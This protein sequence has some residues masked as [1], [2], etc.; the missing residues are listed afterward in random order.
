MG[1]FGPPNVERMKNKRDVAGL[2]K[3]L[4]YRK[5]DKVRQAAMVA[6]G[7]I[8]DARAIE[9]LIAML[10][11]ADDGMRSAAADALG[12]I[13][14]TLAV[15][16]LIA[17]LQDSHDQVR[18]SAAC[19]L[20]K[21]GDAR[22]VEPLIA[23][24]KGVDRKLSVVAAGALGQIGDARAV[25]A[26]TAA[27]KRGIYRETP[28]AAAA[29]L[30]R[31]G[32]PAVGPLS[33]ALKDS[34]SDVR[35]S[36]VQVLASIGAACAVEP[37]FAALKDSHEGVRRAAAEALGRI[38]DARAVEPLIS[39]LN[40][41]DKKDGDKHARRA[42]A[43]ALTKI[44]WRPG[45]D[46]VSVA[47]W[48]AK[49][50]WWECI[51]IGAPAVDPLIDALRGG[52]AVAAS[53]LGQIGDAR[54]VEP[55]IA[56]L[57]DERQT[58]RAEAA[59]EALGRIGDARAIEPLIAVVKRASS[60]VDS[61]RFRASYTHDNHPLIE[62]EQCETR[63]SKE[64]TSALVRIADARAVEPLT[65][66]L[67]DGKWSVRHFAA[68]TLVELYKSGSLDGTHK[69]LI[70]AQRG[71]ISAGHN[72]RTTCTSGDCSHT[73]HADNGGIGIAFPV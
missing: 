18:Y 20:L 72:D 69:G 6:L 53:A 65:S 59:A 22:A 45:K 24:L 12:Q 49:E 2:I 30:F 60:A 62:A 33:S 50:Q 27:L 58:V 8:G 41:E 68:M 46:Q 23:A 37:L 38:G 66:M 19:A 31:I 47:Y 17:V 21:V 71:R 63:M 34:D 9:S 52:S 55:L 25:E 4:S 73:D 39:M 5:D 7:Q 13:G 67:M 29:A 36:A 28:Q 10:K 56:A 43:D 70:L 11:D 16:P 3:A 26:L 35:K 44:G 15:E 40:A 64:A 42:A 48:G 32:T 51:G 57:V 1:L 14:D 54:A 61:A